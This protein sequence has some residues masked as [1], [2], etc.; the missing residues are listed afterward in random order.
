[1]EPDG[2]PQLQEPD[3]PPEGC[4]VMILLALVYILIGAFLAGAFGADV[5]NGDATTW[6]IFWPLRLVYELG[7]FFHKGPPA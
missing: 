3:E 1:M 5:T 2:L 7:L 6:V 4:G